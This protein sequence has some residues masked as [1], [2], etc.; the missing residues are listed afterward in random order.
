MPLSGV[1][2]PHGLPI[3]HKNISF[4]K[5]GLLYKIV[6]LRWK[7]CVLPLEPRIY[8]PQ[9]VCSIRPQEVLPIP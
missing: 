4:P 1:Q 6:T 7:N 9:S 2:V 3:F 8:A 5:T